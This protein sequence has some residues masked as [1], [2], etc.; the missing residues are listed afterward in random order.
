MSQHSDSTTAPYPSGNLQPQTV[1]GKTLGIVSVILPFVGFGLIGLILGIVAKSQSKKAGAK[2]TP[3]VVGIVL[4][5]ISVVVGIIVTIAIIVGIG[6]VAQQCQQLGPGTHQIG[7][8]TIT[9][10]S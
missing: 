10:G 3:A 5:A 6:A 4:G 2:N 8:S 1:P 7:A 9:C